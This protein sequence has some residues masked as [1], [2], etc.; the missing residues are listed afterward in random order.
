MQGN[1]PLSAGL[2]YD[3][4]LRWQDVLTVTILLRSC[5]LHPRSSRF[6]RWENGAALKTRLIRWETGVDPITYLLRVSSKHYVER[7][8]GLT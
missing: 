6:I 5:Y 4:G 2:Q 8:P 7:G 1:E 3:A